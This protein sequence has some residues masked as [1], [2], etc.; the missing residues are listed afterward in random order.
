MFLKFFIHCWEF[1][2][3]LVTFCQ[4][5]K[6][7]DNNWTSF[8]AHRPSS[9]IQSITYK[10]SSKKL[11]TMTN[12]KWNSELFFLYFTILFFFFYLKK[13]TNFTFSLQI[14][15]KFSFFFPF[16]LFTFFSLFIFKIKIQFKSKQ[17][18]IWKNE[19]QSFVF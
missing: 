7:L 19:F 8:N 12:P 4:V 14:K 16:C 17:I 10:I 13:W 11:L 1:K 18:R 3:E 15:F 6:V 5:W 2:R 9:E